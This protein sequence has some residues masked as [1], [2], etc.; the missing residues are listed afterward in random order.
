MNEPG[1]AFIETTIACHDG[2]NLYL[3]RAVGYEQDS[4]G[5]HGVELTRGSGDAV[6][7]PTEDIPAL[8]AALQ[9]LVDNQA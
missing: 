8:I 7:V 1:R 3:Y 9:Q 2:W 5:V 4:R 6:H